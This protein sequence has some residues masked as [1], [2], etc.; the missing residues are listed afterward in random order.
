MLRTSYWVLLQITSVKTK[1]RN[2]SAKY[3]KMEYFSLCIL[4]ENIIS[5]FYNLWMLY[6]RSEGESIHFYIYDVTR[7]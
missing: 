3:Q 2:V 6:G 4:L 7:K 1:E 5:Y